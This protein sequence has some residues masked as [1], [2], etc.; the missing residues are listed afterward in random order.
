M[1]TSFNYEGSLWG[2][3]SVAAAVAD[4]GVVGGEG[5]VG[6]IRGV[7]GEFHGDT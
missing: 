5:A 2:D 3:V 4:G 7:H 1:R 6:A